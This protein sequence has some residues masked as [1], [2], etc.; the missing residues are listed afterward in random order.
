METLQAHQ[1]LSNKEARA[2]SSDLLQEV[3]IPKG[4]GKLY[5]FELSGGISQRVGIAL[6]VCNNPSCSLPTNPPAPWTR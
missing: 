2:R 6:A 3:G 4:H 5:P 1:Q